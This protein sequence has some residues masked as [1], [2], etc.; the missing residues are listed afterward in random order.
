VVREEAP[1]TIIVCTCNIAF[2]KTA[3]ANK[4]HTLVY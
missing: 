4:L 1:T 3:C 2:Q